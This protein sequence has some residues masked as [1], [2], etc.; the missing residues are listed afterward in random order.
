M[1]S[2]DMTVLN[3]WYEESGN[4]GATIGSITWSGITVESR[5]YPL[6]MDWVAA[7]NTITPFVA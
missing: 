1:R 6:V 2:Y 3:A 4:I 5:F 7:G